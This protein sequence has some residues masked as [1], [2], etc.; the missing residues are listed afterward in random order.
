MNNVLEEGYG[1][2]MRVKDLLAEIK[3]GLTQ[4][5]DD[6][7]N[8]S[9]YTEQ[10]SE[11]DKEYKRNGGQRGWGIITMEE[12]PEYWEYFECCGF[13]GQDEKKRVFTINVNY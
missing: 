13:W 5:G 7:L 1:G 3:R 6:F 8:W 11:E 9:V 4:Y 2:V 12:G 10:L